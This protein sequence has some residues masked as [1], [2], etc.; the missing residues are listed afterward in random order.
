MK[1]RMGDKCN[2]HF[3]IATASDVTVQ[4]YDKTYLL[5]HGD[6]FDNNPG[7]C[8]ERVRAGD[9]A[10]RKRAHDSK[11]PV[12][13]V[14]ICGHYHQYQ[15]VGN[16]ITNGSLVGYNEFAFH[17]N[18]AIERPQQALFVQHPALGI[19]RHSGVFADEPTAVKSGVAPVS[20]ELAY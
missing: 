16:I 7:S 2:V 11:L 8:F 5:T 9:A 20:L 14:L 18:L 13:D 4:V 19:T 15:A 1:A 6:Q 10:K 3:K 12:H 17:S